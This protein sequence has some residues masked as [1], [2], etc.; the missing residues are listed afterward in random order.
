MHSKKLRFAKILSGNPLFQFSCYGFDL[1]TIASYG[2]H[3]QG[4]IGL[5]T[6]GIFW[7]FLCHPSPLRLPVIRFGRIPQGSQMLKVVD[8]RVIQVSS[9]VEPFYC[10]L[11]EWE[12][13]IKKSIYTNS[14]VN[15]DSFYTNF[16]NTTFQKF[17]IPHLTR[18]MGQKFL[19]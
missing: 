10:A 6:N 19:H 3:A 9:K 15:V 11:S 16:T 1:S 12:F 13:M 2:W 7:W 4:P 17:P 8:C 14:L 18:P 5:V